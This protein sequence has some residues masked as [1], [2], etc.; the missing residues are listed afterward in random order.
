[1]RPLAST[2]LIPDYYNPPPGLR[3]VAL[4]LALRAVGLLL[5]VDSTLTVLPMFT[6]MLVGRSS[7]YTSS[8]QHWLTVQGQPVCLRC[9]P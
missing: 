9:S 1:M 2:F 6:E 4:Q 7:R 3:Y 8:C 5:G